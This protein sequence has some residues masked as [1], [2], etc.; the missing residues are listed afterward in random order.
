MP[1]FVYKIKN[2]P[3]EDVDR[4]YSEEF[5]E[6]IHDVDALRSIGLDAPQIADTVTNGFGQPLLCPIAT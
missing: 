1:F 3:I 2:I 5:R 6:G 4:V